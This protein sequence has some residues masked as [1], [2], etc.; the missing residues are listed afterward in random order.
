MLPQTDGCAAS[1]ETT[2]WSSIQCFG[3]ALLGSRMRKHLAGNG[4]VRPTQASD[5]HPIIDIMH[6]AARSLPSILNA[7]LGS[8]GALVTVFDSDYDT[9]DCTCIRACTHVEDLC[10]A[11]LMAMECLALHEGLHALSL[12]T[13]SGSSVSEVIAKRTPSDT[14]ARG[15]ARALSTEAR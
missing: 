7:A 3:T 5:Q 2:P 4:P 13:G 11:S 8:D 1:V 12:G 9:P 10:A 6:S 14:Q 15:I